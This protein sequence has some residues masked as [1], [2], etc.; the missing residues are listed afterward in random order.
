MN[1]FPFFHFFTAMVYV[2]LAV[3]IFLKSPKALKNRLCASFLL[4]F[5]LWSFSMVFMHNPAVSK[6]TARV[7]GNISSIGWVSFSSLFIWFILAFTGKKEILKKKW[8]Y[9]ILLGLPL[10]FVYKQWTNFIYTDYI[11]VYS[12]WKPVLGRSVWVYL[13]ALYYLSFMAIGLAIT[14]DFIMKTGNRV[15]RKQAKIIFVSSLLSLILGSIT[16]MLLPYLNI[17]TIPD[18]AD[19]LV[20]IWAFGVVY[21]MVRYKFLSITPATAA[22]NIIS[23]MFDCLILLDMKGNIAAVNKA[24]LE[25]SGYGEEELKG[26]PVHSL[27]AADEENLDPPSESLTEGELKNKDFILKTKDNKKIPVILSSSL[28]RD[29]A[30]TASG[31]VCVAKDIS[32]RKRLEEEVFKSRKLESVGILAGGIA[33]D[34]NNLFTAMVGY[35]SM[36]RE[37]TEPA[38]KA[39]RF[40][41]KAEEISLKA[42]ALARRFITLSPGGWVKRDKVLFSQLWKNMEIPGLPDAQKNITCDIDISGNLAPIAGDEELLI[43]VMEN[44]LVNAVEAVPEEGGRISV[45]AKNKSIGTQNNLLLKKGKYVKISVKDNGGGISTG[46]MEKIFDPYFSTKSKT[47]Q[48]GLGLGLTVCYSIIKKHDGHIEVESSPAGSETGTGTT[49]T[50]YLPAVTG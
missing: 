16:N 25:V 22:R 4:S 29:D 30:G 12:G 50:L 46:I 41:T 34:F 36:A 49:V 45:R 3:Y 24:A 31:M 39:I 32:G 11:L 20:L 9:V 48:K 26:V 1:I 21:V 44:L 43:Q 38:N 7:W 33:H 19:I 28:L 37:K 23:T 5:T 8:L 17:H 27:L 35:I 42:A 6:D 13:F 15:L 47:Y 10:L 18:I 2:Y 14:I 40:L